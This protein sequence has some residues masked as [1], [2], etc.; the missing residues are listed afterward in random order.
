MRN[1][2][3][4]P[5]YT[6]VP[7]PLAGLDGNDGQVDYEDSGGEDHSHLDECVD[8]IDANFSHT[9]PLHPL[10]EE[11]LDDRFDELNQT[12]PC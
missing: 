9:A 4:Q 5:C 10:N 6:M 3:P 8:E 7:D 2:V 12:L 11:R 1:E